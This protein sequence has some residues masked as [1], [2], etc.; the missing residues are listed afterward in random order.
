MAGH[1]MRMSERDIPKRLTFSETWG[2]RRQGRPELRW[3]DGVTDDLTKT[4]V[5]NWR[6]KAQ[7]RDTWRKIVEKAKAHLEL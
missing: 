3:L 2:H 6:R 5:R 4:G 1:V 7:D